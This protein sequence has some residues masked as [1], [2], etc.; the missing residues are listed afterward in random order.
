MSTSNSTL[1]S[2]PGSLLSLPLLLGL[3]LQ[4]RLQPRF[5]L[6]LEFDLLISVSGQTF[7]FIFSIGFDLVFAFA[8]SLGFYLRPWLLLPAL[9]STSTLALDS[10]SALYLTSDHDFCFNFKFSLRPLI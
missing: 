8:L 1:D 2:A 4:F 5:D 6:R 9:A 10:A 7:C 3:Q